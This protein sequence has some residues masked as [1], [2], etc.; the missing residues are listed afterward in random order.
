MANI[1]KIKF[2]VIPLPKEAFKENHLAP[3][4][5]VVGEMKFCIESITHIL[6]TNRLKV[7]RTWKHSGELQSQ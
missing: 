5:Q 6:S 2:G 3:Q 4:P 1:K 7:I